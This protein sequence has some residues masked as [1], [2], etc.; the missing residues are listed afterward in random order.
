MAS[1][2]AAASMA[3]SRAA[4]FWLSMASDPGARYDDEIVIDVSKL[5]P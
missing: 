1:A 3:W 4:S 5:E 2:R